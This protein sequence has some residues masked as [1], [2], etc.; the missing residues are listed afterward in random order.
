MEPE[1]GMSR[2]PPNPAHLALLIPAPDVMY[3]IGHSVAEDMPRLRAHILVARG[4]D[5]LVC[6]Q[7]GAVGEAHAPGQDLGDVDALLDLDST[8][9]NKTRHA[10]V[11]VVTA[12]ALEVLAE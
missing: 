7:L 6:G 8:L 2:V 3:T 9:C 4:E 5:D 11:D 12:A 10:H 1:P